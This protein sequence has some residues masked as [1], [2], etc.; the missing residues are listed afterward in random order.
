M[1]IQTGFQQSRRRNNLDRHKLWTWPGYELIQRAS[2]PYWY[3][4]GGVYTY[5]PACH[6]PDVF[7]AILT[8][9]PYPIK[10]IIA[11]GNNALLAYANTR[12]VYQALK[13]PHLELFV[14][15][16]QW[17]IPTAM[18]AD[19]VFPVATWLEMPV[20]HLSTLNGLAQYA[21][22]G[23]RVIDP[24][25]ERKADYDFYRGLGLRL[26]QEGYWR[27]TLDEEWDFFLNPS[28]MN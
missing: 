19:Y 16:E 20:M 1:N 22:V 10:A 26:G 2:T 23:E 21:A 28:S 17:M 11:G 12:K 4:K 7:R 3:G 13:S 25:Y 9:K 6:E 27:D 18:L 24:L 15:L 5:A 14:I 8:E